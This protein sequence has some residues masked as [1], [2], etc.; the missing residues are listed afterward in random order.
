MYSVKVKQSH[1]WPGQAFLMKKPVAGTT[2]TFT[3]FAYSGKKWTT[4]TA[5]P[6][7]SKIYCKTVVEKITY[8]LI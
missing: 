4:E 7:S 6:Y 2:F 8:S 5:V 1:Y 3:L